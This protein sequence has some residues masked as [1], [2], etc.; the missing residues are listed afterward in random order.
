M[1]HATTWKN[2]KCILLNEER[3]NQNITQCVISSIYM[4]HGKGK[5]IGWKTDWWLPRNGERR[6]V[7]QKAATQG[8]LQGGRTLLYGSWWVHNSVDLLKPTELCVTKCKS[9]C[10]KI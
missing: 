9:F 6:R 2:F 4:T 10:V 1:I 3:Q 8:N 7:K 5:T